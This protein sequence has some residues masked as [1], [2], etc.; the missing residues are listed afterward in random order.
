MSFVSVVPEA[1]SNAA[2]ALEG[3]GSQVT[4][5]GSAAAAPTTGIAAAAQD[6]VSTALSSMFSG[7][8]QE[9]QELNAQAQAYH[10]QFVGTLNGGAGQYL[11]AE[12]TNVQQTLVNA[13]NAPA[14]ALFGRPV[15][16]NGAS[17]PAASSLLGG[18]LPPQSQEYTVFDYE[19]PLGPLKLTLE[20][21]ATSVTGGILNV[22][23]PYAL[24]Y[25]AISPPLASALALQNGSATFVNAVQTGN[26]QL[27]AQTFFETPLNAVSS[28]FA[29][30]QTLT[31]SL[32]LDSSQTGY[33]SLAYS[34]P[35]GGLF[36]PLEPPQVTL[37][38]TSGAPDSFLLSGTEFGGIFPGI[39]SLFPQ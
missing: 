30:G 22:G 4:A 32:P 19:T 16:G 25:D 12:A 1:V 38:S 27:A 20:V 13:V 6:E 14:E 5:A 15:I 39:A 28:F 18:L 26:A 33:S 37:Y 7:Y 35:V 31:G 11:S 17:A 2:K 29:G 10:A 34:V 23:T 21:E 8:G 9:F 24:A 3:I 36:G